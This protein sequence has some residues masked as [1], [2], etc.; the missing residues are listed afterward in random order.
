MATNITYQAQL[1]VA[2][3]PPTP[4]G[5]ILSVDQTVILSGGRVLVEFTA[6]PGT[7]V[8]HPI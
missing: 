8:C 4:N 1:A 3:T 5:T 6:T 2:T 7:D